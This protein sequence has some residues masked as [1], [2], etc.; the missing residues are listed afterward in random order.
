MWAEEDKA[1]G[2]VERR[3]SSTH[4]S[5]VAGTPI[6]KE[7]KQKTGPFLAAASP[8]ANLGHIWQGRM[9]PRHLVPELLDG[10][11][12]RA[13]QKPALAG[14]VL[15]GGQAP[16]LWSQAVSDLGEAT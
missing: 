10:H 2:Q 9:L 4:L 14:V 6:T 1:W 12:W 8:K 11:C 5:Y 16:G 7:E 3:L 13:C 15:H